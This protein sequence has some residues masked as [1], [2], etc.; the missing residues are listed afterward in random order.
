MSSG[1]GFNEFI[2]TYYSVVQCG[3]EVDK[4]DYSTAEIILVADLNTPERVV[5]ALFINTYARENDRILLEGAP[6]NE[7]IKKRKVLQAALLDTKAPIAGWDIAYV[8]SIVGKQCLRI[9]RLEIKYLKAQ[10]RVLYGDESKEK[11][12]ELEKRLVAIR[13]D[14]IERSFQLDVEKIAGKVLDTFQDRLQSMIQ[15]IENAH[16]DA[17]RRV[18][19][20][21][22]RN[23]LTSEFEHVD[24]RFDAEPFRA[25]V[26]THK[27]LVLLQKTKKMQR[28][29]RDRKKHDQHILNMQAYSSIIQN[30]VA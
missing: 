23:I 13:S 28:L 11:K 1:V 25:Y 4:E 9:A 8:D 30:A 16:A 21:V 7:E 17:N 10:T 2:R 24:H 5:N 29:Y 20:V 26:S 19:V 6:S 3:E 14:S 22:S 18:F 12:A 27:V 15:S